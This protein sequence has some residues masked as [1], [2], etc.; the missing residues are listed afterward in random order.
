M[1]I[2]RFVQ[3]GIRFNYSKN[4]IERRSRKKAYDLI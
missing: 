3:F 4:T 1:A 2:Y